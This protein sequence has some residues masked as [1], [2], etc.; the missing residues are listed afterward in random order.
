MKKHRNKALI[1]TAILLYLLHNDWWNWND[2]RLL[3]GLPVGL[4]YHLL[5]CAAS[6]IVLFLLVYRGRGSNPE[7][8][9]TRR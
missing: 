1:G 8:D 4:L 3:L 6:A 5:F 9:K 7:P 2:A